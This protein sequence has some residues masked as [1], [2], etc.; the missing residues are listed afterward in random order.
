MTTSGISTKLGRAILKNARRHGFNSFLKYRQR[1]AAMTIEEMNIET[2]HPSEAYFG[3]SR[4]EKK[5]NDTRAYII[6]FKYL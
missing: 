2:E 6:D 5:M 1:K 4:I 3:I